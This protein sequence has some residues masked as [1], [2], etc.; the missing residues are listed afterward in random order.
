MKRS[1]R[2][3]KKRIEAKQSKGRIVKF[4]NLSL[5]IAAAETD[6]HH[7]QETRIHHF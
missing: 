6:A 7:V 5:F 2:V 4:N 3:R 1:S